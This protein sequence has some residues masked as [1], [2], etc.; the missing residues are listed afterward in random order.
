MLRRRQTLLHQLVR[1]IGGPGFPVSA[2][3]SAG[4]DRQRM[5]AGL[6]G[7]VAIIS[8]DFNVIGLIISILVWLVPMP[9]AFDPMARAVARRV[10]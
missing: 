10:L 1:Q 6:P 5:R 9:P 2:E 8:Q 4:I 7:Q 3:V